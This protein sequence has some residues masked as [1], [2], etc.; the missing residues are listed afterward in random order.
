MISEL[1]EG[2]NVLFLDL[3]TRKEEESTLFFLTIRIM[4]SSSKEKRT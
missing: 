2:L 3:S 1:E 4:Y